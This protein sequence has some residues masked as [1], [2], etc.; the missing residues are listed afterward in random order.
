MKEFLHFRVHGGAADDDFLEPATQR[1]YQF[2]ADLPV[3]LSVQQRNAERPF[4]GLFVDNRLNDILVYLFNHKGDGYNQIGFYFFKCLHQDF[5]R[6]HFAQQR[7]MSAHSRSGQEVESAT[8][9]MCQRQEREHFITFL[10]QFG[11]DA[12]S[13]VACQ[14][15]SGQHNAFAETRRTRSIVQQ[16]YFVIGK[17]GISHIFPC[18]TIRIG[19][20]HFIA[21]MFEETLDS[22]S[23]TLIQAAEII[24]REYSAQAGKPFF[25]QMLPNG[26]AGKEEYRFGMIND[27]MYIIGVEILQDRNYD[28]AISDNRHIS[29]APAGIILAD[30][31][32][33]IAAAQA[34]M[35]E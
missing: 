27:V 14:V 35:L 16:H 29:D 2:L 10:Q 33:L 11:T 1:I 3:Y 4:H 20:F 17:V 21:Q 5:G 23:V 34:A 30:N 31:R 18:E 8:V 25:F 12:E 15:V 28:T 7:D 19:F 24:E 6:R 9:S 26:I 22:L 13:Y 32:Y